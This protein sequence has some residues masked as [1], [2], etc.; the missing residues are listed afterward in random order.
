[1]CL[2]FDWNSIFY[3]SVTVFYTPQRDKPV[4]L[5]QPVV[6]EFDSRFNSN[7]FTPIPVF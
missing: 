4:L 2:D 6:A 1:M 7:L 5:A 3:N